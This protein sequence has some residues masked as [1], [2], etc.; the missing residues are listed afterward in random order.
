MKELRSRNWNEHSST[1]P[2]QMSGMLVLLA[3]PSL[4]I[5][6]SLLRTNWIVTIVA[7]LEECMQKYG[8]TFSPLC[9]FKN[10]FFAF[11]INKNMGSDDVKDDCLEEYLA[12]RSKYRS[13]KDPKLLDR[14]R[15]MAFP[16][17]FKPESWRVQFCILFYLYLYS[18][19]KVNWEWKLK[20]SIYLF[21]HLC[22]LCNIDCKMLLVSHNF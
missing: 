17:L 18:C 19:I 14:M 10:L 4:H 9:L 21:L 5:I 13:T 3:T 12:L 22:S 1:K 8:F 15:A 16:S 7:A 2:L 6:F 11:C 20:S